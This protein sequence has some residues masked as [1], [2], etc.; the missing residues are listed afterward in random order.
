MELAA[1]KQA[2]PG[3]AD[4]SHYDRI[5]IFG[6]WL[7]VHKS[8]ATFTGADIAKCYDL[9]HFSKPSSFGSYISQLADKKE[10]L[11]SG[12]GYR[13]ENR[14]REQIDASYGVPQITVKVT[15]LLADLAATIP[16]MAERAYYQEALIC[17]KH[18]S[19]RGTVIMTWNIAF[20][21]LCDHV[22][23]KRLADFNARWQVTFPGM[24]KGNKGVKAI[25]VFDDFAE[26]LKEQQVLEICRD[27]GIIGKNIFNIMH[28]ALGKRNAA[29]HPNAVVID[30]VQTDAYISDLITNVVQKI[31]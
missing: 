10:L 26:E 2:V 5:K 23:A 18:G 4:K 8:Q 11:K 9:M 31:A 15:S 1:L 12:S 28:A 3:L 25:S 30:Q 21:H 24:H 6:W 16:D 29:A 14:I 7:H 17:Y 19:R 27:A 22:V 13:L 20:S